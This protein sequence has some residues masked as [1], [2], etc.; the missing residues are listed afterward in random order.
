M[1]IPKGDQEEAQRLRAF[2]N[3]RYRDF[4]LLESGIKSLTPEYG[5]LL[6]RCKRKAYC[7]ALDFAGVDSSKP[8]RI[9][10]GGCGQGFFATVAREV[11]QYPVYTGVDISEKAISFL[12][13]LFPEFKWMWADLCDRGCFLDERFDVVQ[14]IEV[15]HLILDD[16]NHSQAISNMASAVVPGG[17]L[18][19][20][21]T[22]PMKINQVNEYIV[23]RPAEYYRRLFNQLGLELVRVF[24]MYYWIPDMGMASQRLRRYFRVLSPDVIYYLDRLFLKLRVPQ[25]RQS[26]DS[27][28]KLIMCRKTF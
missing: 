5:E 11:F 16:R 25:V 9:L 22:L 28:M 24:P 12:K 27:R 17:N 21:D 23:F 26:H 7:K 2:W 6:Y 4:S 18:I 1:H 8:I 13:P 15:L 10:D 20:T 3:S 14:S 19:I